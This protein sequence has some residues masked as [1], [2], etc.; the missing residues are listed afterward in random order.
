MGNDAASQFAAFTG[1]EQGHLDEP[2]KSTKGGPIDL[3][4][5]ARI[6]VHG[7]EVVR[8]DLPSDSTSA[9]IASPKPDP[10]PEA[11]AEPKKAPAKKTSAKAKAK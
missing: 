2:N 1:I 11:K 3:E 10:E 4:E 9:Q 6:N 5:R 8:H 7:E